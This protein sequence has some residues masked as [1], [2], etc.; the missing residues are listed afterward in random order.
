MTVEP[1]RERVLRA[2]ARNREPGYHFAGHFLDIGFDDVGASEV[3]L[4]LATGAH[5][6]DRD[7]NIDV[8]ALAP[9]A[10][11]ALAASVRAALA[12]VERL[13]TVSMDLRFTGAPPGGRLD[14]V[15]AFEGASAGN[16]RYGMCRVRIVGDAGRTVCFGT[17]TFAALRPPTPLAP[18]PLARSPRERE[19]IPDLDERELSADEA[20]ILRRAD[21]AIRAAARGGES[22]AARFW[23]YRTQHVAAGASGEMR[24][25][26]HVRNRVGHAQ[27]GIL[28]GLA[29]ATASAALSPHWTLAGLSAWYLKP[30]EGSVLRAVSRVVHAGRQTAVVRTQVTGKLRQRVLDVVSSHVARGASREE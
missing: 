17:A 10:D 13:A 15:S 6:M 26:P 3:K 12:N 9:F 30:G 21:E 24:N 18:H 7:G 22:F 4:S 19:A 27:G 14:A 28:L 1:I 29:A 23:G 16:G 11:V 20:T 2:I 5:C 25:E 8:G